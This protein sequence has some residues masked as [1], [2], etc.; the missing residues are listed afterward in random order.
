MGENNR[1]ETEKGKVREKIKVK[2]VEEKKNSPMCHMMVDSLEL[3]HDFMQ[4]CYK[5]FRFSRL[6]IVLKLLKSIKLI[7]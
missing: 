6:L 1:S 5:I 7:K 2:L 4:S 3:L